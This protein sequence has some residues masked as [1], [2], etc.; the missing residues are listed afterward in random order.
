M[1]ITMTKKQTNLVTLGLLLGV[2]LEALDGT[3]VG[4]AMPR[5]VTDLGGIELLGWVF[6]AYILSSTVTTP[7]YG[8]LSDLYGRMPFYLGGMAIFM[9]GSIA[10]GLAQDMTQLVIFRGVQGLG[11]GAMMPVAIALA[12]TVFPPE[13][14]G[15][16]Q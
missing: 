15:K 12:Q 3:I 13:E 8:K 1:N 9:A 2:L 16:I 10:C 5:V 11:A 7:I 14:R 4:T 6:S